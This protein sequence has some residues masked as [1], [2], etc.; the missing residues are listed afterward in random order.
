MDYYE[1][2]GLTKSATPEQIRRVHKSLARL[3]HPDRHQDPDLRLLAECQMKRL[4]EIVSVLTDPQRRMAYDAGRSFEVRAAPERPAWLRFAG[5]NWIWGLIGAL[6][7]GGTLWYFG[8][9]TGG[10]PMVLLAPV[11]VAPPEAP[12]SQPVS[13]RRPDPP[14][15]PEV[16]KLR[17]ASEA[18]AMAVAAPEPSAVPLPP[19]VDPPPQRL[20]M[21]VEPTVPPPQPAPPPA[22]FA[23][24]WLYSQIKHDLAPDNVYPAEYVEVVV[25]EEAGVL[26]GRYRARYRVADRLISPEVAFQFTGQASQDTAQ[27]RWTGSG[28]TGEGRLKLL[29]PTSLE[30]TWWATQLGR[31]LGL[32]SG[33]AVL[34]RRR[35]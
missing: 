34:T 4:N 6:G 29:S 14:P 1:E 21:S 3:L 23:G 24:S 32:A 35:Q 27:L 5:P 10:K 2:L 30:V 20:E 26:A 12:K 33:T 7:L 9:E 17:P 15:A 22:G 19:G 28:A 31:N 8:G 18:P 16:G 13:P 11:A 25:T